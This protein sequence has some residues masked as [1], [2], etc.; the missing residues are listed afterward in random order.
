MSQSP[1]ILSIFLGLS[2]LLA[3]FLAAWA[4][5]HARVP[6]ARE[7]FFLMLGIAIYSLGYSISIP[8]T[9]LE[10]VFQAIHFEYI[11][12]AFMPTLL[13]LFALHF[14]RRKP[15]P[16]A[17][18][19]LLLVI[20]LITLGLVFTSPSHQLYYINP[21]LVKTEFFLAFAFEPGPWYKVNSIWTELTIIS[22]FLLLL[23]NSVRVPL[24]QKQQSKIGRAS[25]RERV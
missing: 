17:L 7:F 14:T 8:R 10:G 9:T 2:A 4:Y 19:A 1:A 18:T 22:A 23:V 12:L 25:C 11:G 6:A 3:V 15:L 20:P 16:K 21:R 5:F 13:L 24:K